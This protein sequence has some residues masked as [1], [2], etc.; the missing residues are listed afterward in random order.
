MLK[1]HIKY[2]FYMSSRSY[3]NLSDAF[4][5][6]LEASTSSE[7]TST[8][9]TSKVPAKDHSKATTKGKPKA[10]ESG[11]KKEL[12]HA[13]KMAKLLGIRVEKWA[14]RQLNRL[15]HK[16]PTDYTDHIFSCGRIH[17]KQLTLLNL[18]VLTH[19]TPN[20]NK[21]VW[22]FM[23]HRIA[24]DVK[25]HAGLEDDSGKSYYGLVSSY[26][27]CIPKSSWI[28][29]FEDEVCDGKLTGNKKPVR[30]YVDTFSPNV[31]V[32]ALS[33]Y[34]HSNEATSIMGGKYVSLMPRLAVLLCQLLN[35][36]EDYSR[37][38]KVKKQKKVKVVETTNIFDVLSDV[39]AQA[40]EATI[41][42][43][44]QDED[45]VREADTELVVELKAESKPVRHTLT[46]FQEFFLDIIAIGSNECSLNKD[47][48]QRKIRSM[49]DKI[50]RKSQSMGMI[51]YV[52][53]LKYSTFIKVMKDEHFRVTAKTAEKTVAHPKK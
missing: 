29:S 11:E 35:A 13:I 49:V 30:E 14:F 51:N 37:S 7:K 26:F 43:A 22:S 6:A 3:F 8:L 33:P 34:I 27:L 18:L 52:S 38:K 2:S 40:K 17:P 39:P 10:L 1:N 25:R 19:L 46:K 41:G 24:S 21:K 36:P 53:H 31:T 50:M 23:M 4:V 9:G 28:T 48:T 16:L 5:A 12:P 47:A 20:C 45:A 44:V 42:D 32:E 15:I